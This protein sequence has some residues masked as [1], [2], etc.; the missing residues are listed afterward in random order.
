[1]FLKGLTFFINLGVKN[2]L[3]VS[4]PKQLNTIKYIAIL[5]GQYTVQ[6]GKLS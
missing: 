5:L 2:L 6:A 1:M 4:C 3:R